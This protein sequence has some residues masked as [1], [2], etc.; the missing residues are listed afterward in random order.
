MSKVVEFKTRSKQ[1]AEWFD[2][3][4]NKNGLLEQSV[5]SAVFL[6]E[7][8]TKDN[9]STCMH[10]TFNCDTDDFEWFKRCMEEQVFRN[11]VAAYLKENINNFIE[12][13]N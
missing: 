7:T 2:E 10:A 6:W 5:Q 8:K 9:L 1:L 12:Y 13:I 11:K 4:V 3:V